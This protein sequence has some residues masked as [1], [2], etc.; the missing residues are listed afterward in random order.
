MSYPISYRLEASYKRG[1]RGKTLQPIT[2]DYTMREVNA[3]LSRLLGSP[4][5]N[6]G[7]AQNALSASAGTASNGMNTSA[8]T[9]AQ[10]AS[11]SIGSS[12][13]AGASMGGP[14]GAAVGTAIG[15]VDTALSFLSADIAYKRQ[16]EFYDTRLSVP[17]QVSQ[18][19]EAGLNPMGLA[20]GSGATSAPAVQPAD[21][22]GVT[23]VLGKL[24]DYKSRM[25]QVAVQREDVASKIEYRAEQKI[26]QQKVNDWFEANQIVSIGQSIADTKLA[27]EK[28]NTESTQQRLNEA[29]ISKAEADAALSFQLAV[30][31]QFENSP[32][33]RANTL[34][35][36]RARANEANANAAQTYEGIK[37][38]AAQRE[39]IASR[40]ALNYAS[41]DIG[42]QQ[43][44][45][46]G[47]NEEQIRFAISHQK[48]D[49]IFNRINQVTSSLKD[50]GIAAASFT[51]TATGVAPLLAAPRRKIGF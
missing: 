31:K 13:A 5:K 19:E 50:V 51:A 41:T 17:A 21:V 9:S 24:L 25:A 29:G 44:I 6:A 10:Q 46:L 37:N 4:G 26:Y 11:S 32:E 3:M 8:Y 1:I 40:I 39:E 22:S 47:L 12:A 42:K 34:A 43:L 27:L 48:G 33:F 49:L 15:L 38:L 18:F 35:L 36:Q 7:K 14:A 20:G 16:K 30:Q 28:V 45:N 2:E 23:D